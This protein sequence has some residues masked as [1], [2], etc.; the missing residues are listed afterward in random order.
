MPSLSYKYKNNRYEQIYIID[1]DTV[2]VGR[3][4][5]NDI[6]LFDSNVSRNHF[7]IK[8]ESNGYYLYDNGSSNGTFLNDA[9]LRQRTKL[10]N[11]DKIAAGNT[12][13]TFTEEELTTLKEVSSSEFNN[14]ALSPSKLSNTYFNTI[15]SVARDGIYPQ[16]KAYFFS[17]TIKSLCNAVKA[18][19]GAIL[20]IDKATGELMLQA[21][22]HENGP[23]VPGISSSILN[24]SIKSRAALLVKN[25]NIDNRFSGDYTIQNMG[26]YSAVCAPIWE[27][28]HIYGAVYADR[29]RTQ[30]PFNEENL[31]F[32]TIIANLLALSIAHERLIQ[33]IAE[34]KSI[35][36][37]IK[38]FV[39]MEAVSGLLKMIKNNPSSMWNIQEVSKTTLMFADIVGFTTLTEK[40]KPIVIARLLRAFFEHAT[41]VVLLNGGSINKFLGDGFMAVFGTPIPA[42]DDPDKAIKSA[43]TLMKWIRREIEGIKL[44]LRIGIDTGPVTGIMVGSTRRLEYTVI[45]NSVNVAARLQSRADVNQI[46][47]SG[48]TNA[49]IKTPVNTKLIGEVKMKG[50]QMPVTVYQVIY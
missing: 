25:A 40:T 19:Y 42:P 27:K 11:L 45:G 20:L 10:K 44:S 8:K 41:N 16:D 34:E 36:E 22:N 43:I 46:L 6:V 21:T 47:I 9:K 29:R 2:S 1:R 38:R 3:L 26:I 37:Q 35:A 7:I 33:T 5:S 23:G 30:I 24:R 50:K 17:S 15:F 49:L 18:E 13:L 31:N 4:P 48:D 39:P 28:D 32:V 12:I 14:I